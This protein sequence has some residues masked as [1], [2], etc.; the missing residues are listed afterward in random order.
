MRLRSSVSRRLVLSIAISA[1]GLVAISAPAWATFP[2][3][4][5]RIAFAGDE[6]GDL[7]IWT[8]NPD[9]SGA[10]N[11]TAGP[12]IPGFDLEPDYS[13]DGTKIAFRSGR[14]ATAEIYTV[15]A[16][17]TGLARLTFNSVKDYTPAWSP[18]GSMIAFASNRNDPAPATCVDLL[19]SCTI[20]IFVMPATGGSPVQVTFG[21]GTKHFPQFSPDG[22]S[23]AYTSNASGAFAVYTVDLDTL[24]ATKLTPDSLHAGPP[25]YSPDGTKIAFESN[26]R[27][28]NTGTSECRSDIFTMNANGTSITRLT[29][30]FGNNYDATWSPEGDKI[31]FTHALGAGFKHQQVYLMNPD[32]TGIARITRTNDESFGSD[33]GSG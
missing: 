21:S 8:I 13:P 6:A 17:G 30:K 12:S 19:G 20:D 15:N 24:A 2:G 33:W 28:C 10:A 22:G 23:I 7:D 25:D 1:F 5:G 29:P 14:V 27:A 32:G 4:N 16:D 18:D 31:A 11:V 3:Q 26:F 9:G